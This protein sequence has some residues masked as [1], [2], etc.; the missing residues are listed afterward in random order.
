MSEVT[1]DGLPMGGWIESLP[2]LFAGMERRL[3]DDASEEAAWRAALA[4]VQAQLAKR[5]DRTARDAAQVARERRKAVLL[6]WARHV[7]GLSHNERAVLAEYVNYFSLRPTFLAYP[8]APTVANATGLAVKTVR[9]VLARLVDRGVLM[10]DDR[11]H[12]DDPQW[13]GRPAAYRAN[14]YLPNL[15]FGLAPSPNNDS[16]SEAYTTG[17][18]AISAN[19]G[20]GKTAGRAGYPQ[21]GQ[22]VHPVDNLLAEAPAY[23]SANTEPVDNFAETAET[24][25]VSPTEGSDL[26]TGWTFCP[27]RVVKLSTKLTPLSRTRG[28]LL[29]HQGET[30]QLFDDGFMVGSPPG[31]ETSG[32]SPADAG[33]AADRAAGRVGLAAP[34]SGPAGL[35]ALDDD[36]PGAPVYR[37]RCPAHLHVEFP[38]PCGACKEARL[39]A[40]ADEAKAEESKVLAAQAAADVERAARRRRAEVAAEVEAGQQWR[41]DLSVAYRGLLGCRPWEVRCEACAGRTVEE[42]AAAP[43]GHPVA[44]LDQ[45][46][47]L[48]PAAAVARAAAG[49][50]KCAGSGVVAVDG[51]NVLCLHAPVGLAAGG[52]DTGWWDGFVGVLD[53][54]DGV[55]FG[56]PVGGGPP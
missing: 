51:V 13:S 54:G 43:C 55:L 46:A 19:G 24:R 53:E 40:E 1:R 47:Y 38:P 30:E 41:A 18:E 50:R 3:H 20:P 52:P 2:E 37:P 34:A 28:D 44:G 49:C 12:G 11:D 22:N 25:D 14:A 56:W 36:G 26:S 8:S 42:Q 29:T 15:A 32:P 17:P 6:V 16:T 48:A 21:G 10:R 5:E 39:R 45:V 31:G 9:R 27:V 23:I 7:R 35:G 33:P 4:A